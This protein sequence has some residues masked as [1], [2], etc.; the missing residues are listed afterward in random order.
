MVAVVAAAP[1]ALA[2]RARAQS[3]PQNMIWYGCY[4]LVGSPSSAQ[5]FKYEGG[6]WLVGMPC[7]TGC[8]NLS[9]AML[10]ASG[11]GDPWGPGCV[12]DMVVSDVYEIG[13][14]PPG[15]PISF[16][17]ELQVTGSFS[18]NG[19]YNATL[20][21]NPPNG[22]KA[23]GNSTDSGSEYVVKIP[24]LHAPGEPFTISMRFGAGGF[25]PAGEAHGTAQLRFYG[26]PSGAWIQSC[27]NY[28]LPV[29]ATRS[30]WGG[31]KA[32]YRD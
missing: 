13:N 30:T 5:S 24:L 1:F 31:L 25:Y 23:S 29:P 20:Q 17:A 8:Y 18:G 22:A 2:S 19:G 27:Q 26:L 32:I 28:D 14:L 4:D 12:T 10:K 7:P 9:A 15:P 6:P 11:Y 3:C 21:E 16:F